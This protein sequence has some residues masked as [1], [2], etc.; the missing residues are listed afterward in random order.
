MKIAFFSSKPYDK[1]F[2]EAENKNYGFEL[3]FYETHLG[4]HIVNAIEDEQA[5]CVFVNDKVNRQVIEILA[6]KGVKIIAL[7]CAGFN[8]VDLEAAKEFGIKVCRVPAYSPEA[9]AEHTMAMLLTL[10]RKTHKAYNRVREQNFALN[11]LLG[12]NLF[13]K[14][15]GIVGTGKIGKAFVNIAKGFG[16]KIIAYDLYPDQELMNNGVEYVELDKLFKSSDI[17]SLHCPLTPENHYMINQETI[18]M[19]KDGVTIINTSRGGLINTHEAIEALK[20]HKIGYLGIDVYEQEEKLFFKDLSAEI[21]QDDMIQ[22]L[23]SFPNVLVTAHQ[24][25][26]TQEALEQISEITMR[27]ISEIKEK[28][29]TDEVVML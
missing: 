22:R 18:A 19:M 20:N 14:T 9:V 21:I 7:R 2:F 4:P 17:I 13:Q 8:N 27:S 16:C 23:M 10:N 1:T 24:A 3:N 25:F 28:G 6:K 26:F 11:G 29:S 5:V 15:I 12:F